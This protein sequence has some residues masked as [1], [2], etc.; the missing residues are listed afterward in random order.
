MELLRKDKLQ[1]FIQQQPDIAL[2]E[3]HPRNKEDIKRTPTPNLKAAIGSKYNAHKLRLLTAPQLESLQRNLVTVINKRDHDNEEYWCYEAQG[4]K[5]KARTVAES[6]KTRGVELPAEHRTGFFS[7]P[8]DKPKSTISWELTHVALARDDR[9][10]PT[11]EHEVSHRCHNPACIRPSHLL[12]EL[13]PTNIAREE[14]RYQRNIT[15][16][17]C[18]HTWSGCAHTPSCL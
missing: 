18:N 13:H 8:C 15:C 14:C 11:S 16:P 12:W 2:N 6:S 3:L 4:R 10:P 5:K 9:L 17:K 7:A 1:E